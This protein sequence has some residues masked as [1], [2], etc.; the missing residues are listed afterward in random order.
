MHVMHT[1]PPSASGQRTVTGNLPG[2]DTRKQ[3]I[4]SVFAE[5]RE[6]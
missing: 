5:R 1:R 4:T 3:P 6:A 2:D